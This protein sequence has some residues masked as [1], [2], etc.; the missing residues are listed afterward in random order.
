MTN[1]EE[2][3]CKDCGLLLDQDRGFIP[4]ISKFVFQVKDYCSFKDGTYRCFRCWKKMV[5]D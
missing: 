5:E 3:Y 4:F 2:K 1:S